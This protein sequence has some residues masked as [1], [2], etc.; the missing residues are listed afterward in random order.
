MWSIWCEVLGKLFRTQWMNKK[1]NLEGI[2]IFISNCCERSEQHSILYAYTIS[3]FWW[4]VRRTNDDCW[5]HG[6]YAFAIHDQQSRSTSLRLRIVPKLAKH[7]VAC[8]FQCV[9]K[10]VFPKYKA[11][12]WGKFEKIIMFKPVPYV[13]GSI[14]QGDEMFSDISRGRQ[15]SLMSFSALLCAQVYPHDIGAVL[16]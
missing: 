4:Y 1:F 5:R 12:F 16:L 6:K 10:A 9:Y 15:C 2:G 11:V 3:L 7:A 14:H 13:A 8:L